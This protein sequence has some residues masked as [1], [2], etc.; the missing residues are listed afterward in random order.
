[1]AKFSEDTPKVLHFPGEPA[2]PGPDPA[3]NSQQAEVERLRDIVKQQE[4]HIVLMQRQQEA[5]RL[6]Q[7]LESGA[8]QF[9]LFFKQNSDDPRECA[10]RAVV[11]ALTQ[12]MHYLIDKTTYDDDD[13]D[14]TDDLTTITMR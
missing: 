12:T 8:V 14:A 3:V 10:L 2:P 6:H 7:V 9:G 4:R 5:T 11:A 13:D 1:M